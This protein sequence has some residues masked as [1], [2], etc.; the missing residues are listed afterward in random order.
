MNLFDFFSKI[1]TWLKITMGVCSFFL[2]LFFYIVIDSYFSVQ[3]TPKGYDFE[4]SLSSNLKP[5]F[6]DEKKEPIVILNEDTFKPKKKIK[7]KIV[8]K[9]KV[10]K[11]KPSVIEEKPTPILEIPFVDSTEQ[12]RKDLYLSRVQKFSNIN[13]LE[14]D[15]EEQIDLNKTDNWPIEKD[16]NTYPT[17]LSRVLTKETFISGML[18]NNIVSTFQGKIIIRID[19]NVFAEHGNLILIPIGS[20]ASGLYNPN[21]KAGDERLSMTIERIITPDGQLIKFKQQAI[22][23]DQQGSTGVPGEVDNRYFQKFGLPILFSLANNTL[24]S[25]LQALVDN[26]IRSDSGSTSLASEIFNEQW[27][28]DQA[29]TNKEIVREFIKEN[30]NIKPKIIV[31]SGEKILFYLQND[32]WFKANLNESREKE[33]L[34]LN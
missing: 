1:P 26:Y 29:N 12:K 32:I 27:L 33:V 13:Y 22:V 2:S 24:N 8:K 6:I 11:K 25:S 4:D 10:R 14:D 17:D 19:K 28:Q 30:I 23:A 20:K 31:P 5:D 21:V 3:S 7:K 16:E 15:F 34:I 9:K 18:I